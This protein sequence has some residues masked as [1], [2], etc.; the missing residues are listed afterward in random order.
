MRTTAQNKGS[1]VW[2]HEWAHAVVPSHSFLKSG[3]DRSAPQ[4]FLSQCALVKGPDNRQRDARASWR[5]TQ[6][7]KIS[8]QT[9]LWCTNRPK[10][11]PVRTERLGHRRETELFDL[12]QP[13]I[14]MMTHTFFS[15]QSEVPMT[16]NKNLPA[17]LVLVEKL[18]HLTVGVS[19][20]CQKKDDWWIIEYRIVANHIL[21]IYPVQTFPASKKIPTA[22]KL[23]TFS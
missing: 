21:S 12:S 16:N 1:L 6:I 18:S 14:L 23:I 19:A 20:S 22:I 11:R 17:V 13:P 2:A 7:L 5:Q 8:Q 3:Q 9:S 15:A 4:V 10:K